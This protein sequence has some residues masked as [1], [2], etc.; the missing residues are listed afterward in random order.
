M[1]GGSET[2]LYGVFQNK[3]P[4]EPLA[5][6]FLYK[7]RGRADFHIQVSAPASGGSI[8]ARSETEESPI[9]LDN[10]FAR[11]SPEQIQAIKDFG[12]YYSDYSDKRISIGVWRDI[13]WGGL[14]PVSAA[15][16]K[17]EED[18]KA[19]E[20][21]AE[22]EA[23]NNMKTLVPLNEKDFIKSYF[24]DADVSLFTCGFVDSGL[25][26]YKEELDEMSRGDLKMAS[27]QSLEIRAFWHIAKAAVNLIT[28]NIAMRETVFGIINKHLKP[29]KKFIGRNMQALCAGIADTRNWMVRIDT[30]KAAAYISAKK[31]SKAPID[32]IPSEIV[33]AA[34][35]E[36]HDWAANAQRSDLVL[37]DDENVQ[38]GIV[39]TNLSRRV[40]AYVPS[41]KKQEDMIAQINAQPFFTPKLE[42]K[43]LAALAK[44]AMGLKKLDAIRK[45]QPKSKYQLDWS[46]ENVDKDRR[47]HSSERYKTLGEAK[48]A[49]CNSYVELRDEINEGG[50]YFE[51]HENEIW[52]SD[53]GMSFGSSGLVVTDYRITRR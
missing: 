8:V 49:L 37:V 25:D 51:N 33:Q 17:A 45:K 15:L 35:D 20:K 19:A 14:S 16:K 46:Y 47:N 38:D 5:N 53:S 39:L 2:V 26:G 22:E 23:I 43:R 7:L 3:G 40:L 4:I 41:K 11:L 34:L 6:Q 32:L 1:T 31:T 50:G 13:K 12:K 28:G 36:F 18:K 52:I 44:E 24:P 48:R 27:K 30:T 9:V 21:V 42:G 29:N 10:Y